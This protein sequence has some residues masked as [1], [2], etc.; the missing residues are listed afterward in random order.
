MFISNWRIFEFLL[1]PLHVRL[2]VTKFFLRFHG[3]IHKSSIKTN[4]SKFSSFLFYF[5]LFIY[6]NA[7]LWKGMKIRRDERRGEFGACMVS[8][9]GY[10]L[11]LTY[12]VF[13]WVI[14]VLLFLKLDDRFVSY[15]PIILEFFFII[16]L[17]RIVTAHD[18]FIEIWK[19]PSRVLNML[20]HCNIRYQIYFRPKVGY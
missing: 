5:I 11:K 20:V 2:N 10:L 4:V 18:F 17:W 1:P 8:S 19:K 7:C 12:F 15:L 13:K 6:F 3:W 14:D 9:I 16:S